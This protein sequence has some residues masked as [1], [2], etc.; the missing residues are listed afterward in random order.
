MEFT[1]S[2]KFPLEYFSDFQISDNRHTDINVS[3]NSCSRIGRPEGKLLLDKH[4]KWIQHTTAGGMYSCPGTDNGGHSIFMCAPESEAVLARM[5]T[6]NNWTNA[7]VSILSGF[8]EAENE[9]LRLFPEILFRNRI[10]FHQGIEIHSS[11]IAWCGKGI[12]FT[13]PSETG[14]ST[15]AGLWI[16]HMKAL[17]L[18]DDRPAIRLLHGKHHVFG[19]PW[20]L[21]SL[22]F[23]N[24]CVQLAAIIVLEQ[25]SENSIRKLTTAEAAVRI[26]PRCYLPYYDNKMM[27]DALGYFEQ[28]ITAT[29][30]YLLSCRPDVG[31]VELLVKCL[32]HK[33][34]D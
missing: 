18:N 31:A 6:D 22:D 4:I 9:A 34:T 2:G 8:P 12:V 15:Q 3:V 7:S 32:L 30:I 29:P 5:D 13:A 21:S 23:T 16:K 14:K 19:T 26:L 27:Q 1:F 28:L 10:L 33:G 11:A 20:G 25:A 17:E 24:I